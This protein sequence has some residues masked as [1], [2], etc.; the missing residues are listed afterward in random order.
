MVKQE[1]RDVI[2]I[3]PGITGSVL[4]KNGRD[5]WA[6]STETLWQ[7][8]RTRGEIVNDLKLSG[9]DGSE[10]L[11]DGIRASRLVA[12]ANLVPGLMK[13]D[14]Y[15][16]TANLIREQFR[17][18]EGDIRQSNPSNPANFFLFP[19]DWR[20][21]N[22]INARILQKHL[23]ARLDE[24]RRG[25]GIQQAKV[26]LLAHSMGGLVSRYYLEVLGGWQN[27]K[28]LFTFGT[29]F[30]G[31]T[32]ALNFIC[33]GFRKYL[34][35]LSDV[36][37]SYPSIY[38]L[39]PTYKVL[40]TNQSNGYERLIDTNV[41]LPHVDQEKLKDAFKFHQ[42]IDEAVEKNQNDALYL[43]SFRVIPF[44][45]IKQTTQQSANY[46]GSQ[47]TIS[48]NL[49]E[50]IDR[51]YGDGDGTVPFRSAI[52]RELTGQFRELYLPQRHGSLQND[53]KTLDDLRVRINFMQ[54]NFE[55]ILGPETE[56]ISEK[57]GM[58]NLTEIADYYETNEAATMDATM[59]VNLVNLQS[60]VSQVNAQITSV[61][62]PG[63]TIA[64]TVA[65]QSMEEWEIIA[66][67]LKPG[68]YRLE[69]S[70][71]D[72]NSPLDPVQEVFEVVG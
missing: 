44:V 56:V 68:I 5:L 9:D 65:K 17:V 39:L 4:Q 35:D 19:Y 32:N 57:Q 2:V 61:S 49:P 25:T 47:V 28:A 29:P 26:I 20:R 41:S 22:R 45:G 3:L 63:E 42:E 27:C 55:D 40:K 7:V 72:S 59:K 24:W 31:S 14:G 36:I 33:N 6:V 64:P 15:T 12:D 30:K 37:R 53:P 48:A 51:Q 60:A 16:A 69:V 46:D 54:A 70:A 58:I 43:K 50:G 71:T 52:P 13:I 66:E 23:E 34:L 1:L 62:Q 67:N 38:Q 11:G 18:V 21:D 8:V 10:F